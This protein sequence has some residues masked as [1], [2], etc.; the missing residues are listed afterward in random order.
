MHG[1]KVE[2]WKDGNVKALLSAIKSRN[3]TS[4]NQG[5]STEF[6]QLLFENPDSG[7]LDL[8][9]DVLQKLKLKHPKTSPKY[10]GL[11]LSGSVNKVHDINLD[12]IYE[13][14]EAHQARQ[15]LMLIV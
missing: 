8:S 12:D 9:A 7:V 3:L 1:E 4:S 14:Q 13:E 2:L 5:I 15:N 6:L 10:D 11:L